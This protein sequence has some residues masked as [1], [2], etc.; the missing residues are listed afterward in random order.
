M[1]AVMKELND[2]SKSMESMRNVI[3]DAIGTMAELSARYTEHLIQH[4]GEEVN[5][6]GNPVYDDD[7]VEAIQAQ[8]GVE[9][10]E[11]GFIKTPLNGSENTI[12]KHGIHMCPYC[13]STKLVAS[14]NEPGKHLCSE[15][16]ERCKLSFVLS[17]TE[18][19]DTPLPLDHHLCPGCQQT[20]PQPMTDR[21]GFY[22][23]AY[24][25]TIHK[26]HRATGFTE[27]KGSTSDE[28]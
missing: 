13:T 15:C 14:V 20:Q 16:G 4:H 24:C 11:P 19:P 27:F 5:M 7:D 8:Q 26:Y 12:V 3:D 23:C 2:C 22:Q 17:Q 18:N 25:D 9:G 1:K 21:I 6:F 10:G 28:K